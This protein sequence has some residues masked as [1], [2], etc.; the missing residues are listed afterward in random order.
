MNKFIYV[1]I[2]FISIILYTFTVRGNWGNPTSSEIDANLKTS[3]QAFETSQER[4]RYALVLSLVNDHTYNIDNYAQ[5]AT[6]DVGRA[7]GHYYSFFPP[8]ASILAVPF[9]LAGHALG[10]A[11]MFTFLISTV[12]SL[13]TMLVIAK[14]CLK[15]G[16]HW[17][18]ALFA[19][20][21]FGFATNAWGYSVT[22][23]AHLISAFILIS[24]LYIT[25]FSENKYIILKAFCIGFLYALAVYIDFPNLLIF[26]PIACLF[27][28]KAF[29]I[30]KD[31]E[32]F[33][34][35]IDWR[36]FIAPVVFIVLMGVYCWTN[37][38]NFG[39]PTVFSNFLPRVRDVV[40]IE[41][42]LQELGRDPSSATNTRNMLEGL[43]SF[44]VSPDRG[45]LKYSPI[46]LLFILGLGYFKDK[47]RNIEVILLTL[48]LVCLLLYSMFGDPY[49][50]WAFGSRY[51]LA[52]LPELCILAAI[53]LQR[54]GI[55]A[56]IL[57]SIVFIYSASVSLLA[58]LTTNVIP[59]SV[60]AGGL[61]L[62]DDY[63]INL[64]M[65]ASSHLNSFFY[66]HVLQGRISGIDYYSSILILIVL[67]GAFAIW[68]PRKKY[69]TYNK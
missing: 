23:Y 44:I 67:I 1:I 65:L 38:V 39:S 59:P 11:Q 26:F 7:N 19:S 60:E 24:G 2:I 22:F 31:N 10:G 27:T 9:Y 53:G 49:G 8:G 12:F 45:L 20:L 37:Y 63:S 35:R 3:G 29:S 4:A 51:M 32:K 15:L 47:R 41:D 42:N 69:E 55:F 64:Q 62:S 54:F 50:G 57:Y 52:V 28:L 25:V 68:F 16:L 40:A 33:E 21:A 6:P 61:G 5:M 36:Y 46:V 18:V 56:K 14:F 66:N 48:P 34:L 43:H 13:L 17:S 58:P 30:N